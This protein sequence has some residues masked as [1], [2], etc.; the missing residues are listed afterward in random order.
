M[1]NRLRQIV[2][3]RLPDRLE[4]RLWLRNGILHIARKE[5]HIAALPVGVG[6][7]G[8]DPEVLAPRLVRGHGDHPEMGESQGVF[9]PLL[10][11]PPPIEFELT[12][13]PFFRHRAPIHFEENGI[14]VAVVSEDEKRIRHKFGVLV[15]LVP[16]RIFQVIA[17]QPLFQ[18]QVVPFPYG[19]R[20]ARLE[21]RDHQRVGDERQGAF[22]LPHT[23]QNRLIL[24]RVPEDGLHALLAEGIDDMR[25]RQLGAA[26][27]LGSVEIPQVVHQGEPPQEV[28][29][30]SGVQGKDL[31]GVQEAALSQLTEKLHVAML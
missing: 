11:P 24:P 21:L 4:N 28:A 1:Q 7:F 26:L 12:H 15:V 5:K 29:P 20:E 6:F 13:E 3:R 16:Q 2:L 14:F 27:G 18:F 30:A 10:P 23:A 19:K 8:G 9:D 22:D 17:L 31:L 25:G